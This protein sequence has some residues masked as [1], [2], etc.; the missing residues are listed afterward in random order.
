[1]IA[2]DLKASDILGW[3]GGRGEGAVPEE[4]SG[5]STDS[6]EPMAGALFVALHGERFDGHAFLSKAK[7]SGAAAALRH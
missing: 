6:R 7:A 4:F 1:M 5:V 3:T 2:V